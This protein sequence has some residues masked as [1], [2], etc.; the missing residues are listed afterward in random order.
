MGKAQKATTIS[1]VLATR[2]SEA[3]VK[4]W[5]LGKASLKRCPKESL[6]HGEKNIQLMRERSLLR[7]AAQEQGLILKIDK[8]TVLRM[9]R[10][11]K[12]FKASQIKALA[13]RIRNLRSRFSTTHLLRVVSVEDRERRDQIVSEAIEGSWTYVTL[14]R[15]V[16]LTL[17][18]RE[19]ES[20][21]APLVPA[22]VNEQLVLLESLATRWLRCTKAASEDLPEAVL[23]VVK[24]ANVAMSAV[25]KAVR[26]SID[27][28]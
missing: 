4:L 9:R 1:L 2:N 23:Q 13:V 28:P 3:L 25:R 6:R 12:D 26:R 14:Y 21:R 22:E 15:H 10:V 24:K 11:A 20:G 17:P 5:Q 19:W 16:Q 8:Y 18:R 7:D 27:R